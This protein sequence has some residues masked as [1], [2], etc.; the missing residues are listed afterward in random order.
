[1]SPGV[2]RGAARPARPRAGTV[3]LPDGRALA[4]HGYGE[5][6][7]APVLYFHGWPGAGI[8]VAFAHAAAR[9]LGVRLLGLDRPGMGGSD[10][11][12]ERTLLDWPTDV[13]A[14][15]DALGLERFAVL[16]CSGGGPFAVACAY[17]LP[18]RVHSLGLLCPMGPL[19]LP[20]VAAA[21]KPLHRAVYPLGRFEALVR[22]LLAPAR[23]VLRGGL[24]SPLVKAG[25]AAVR[26]V[27]NPTDRVA[28][29]DPGLMRAKVRGA[30]DAFRQGPRGAAR[31]GHILS[32]PWG[33]SPAEVRQP[34]FLWHGEADE[35][36]PPLMSR[37]MAGCMPDARLHLDPEGGHT[38]VQLDFLP[39]ALEV[40]PGAGRA[41]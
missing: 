36:V 38:S 24:D 22:V 32:S 4:W 25:V 11:Q 1:M 28:L 19:E 27:K 37:A 18:E 33:F 23:G 12:P 41:T 10:P 9:R 6:Q 16:G 39:V 40:L 3:R 34:A 17:A 35:K 8:E 7:G 5:P 31:D 21:L 20:E 26:A 15:A 29:G 13:A 14:L 2:R 30:Q